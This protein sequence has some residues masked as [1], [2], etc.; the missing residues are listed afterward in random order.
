MGKVKTV[1]RRRDFEHLF[2][3]GRRHRHELLTTV[4]LVRDDHSPP[5][6][7]FIAGRK[8][9][10]AVVR[11]KVRRRLRQAWRTFLDD[12]RLP[13]DVALV[14]HPGAATATYTQL[15]AVMARHLRDA[16]LLQ[17]E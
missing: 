3:R 7:A 13:A 11:N 16:Q 15:L 1:T 8:V 9:G 10:K 12:I 4:V 14:A 6:A 17:D 5:R 2:T